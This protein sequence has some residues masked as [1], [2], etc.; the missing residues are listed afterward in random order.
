MSIIPNRMGGTIHVLCGHVCSRGLC[1][2]SCV[3]YALS[4]VQHQYSARVTY[5]GS[6]GI[7]SCVSEG[8]ERSGREEEEKKEKEKRVKKKEK[9]IGRAKGDQ[10]KVLYHQQRVS[11]LSIGQRYGSQFL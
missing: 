7:V 10:D 4:S 5:T 3:Q 9:K 11:H 1:A 8:A 6:T 2:G